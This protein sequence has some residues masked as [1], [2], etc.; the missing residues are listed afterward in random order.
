MPKG[1]WREEKKNG[2]K[3]KKKKKEKKRKERNA[4]VEKFILRANLCTM[5]YKYLL[6]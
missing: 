5:T 4:L 3:K 2:K 1:K 6:T